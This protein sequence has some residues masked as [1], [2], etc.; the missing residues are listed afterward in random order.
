MFYHYEN[1]KCIKMRWALGI[2]VCNSAYIDLQRSI[3]Y[4][5]KHCFLHFEGILLSMRAGYFHEHKCLQP[6]EM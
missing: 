4:W 5:N 6:L 3:Y 1:S 2:Y